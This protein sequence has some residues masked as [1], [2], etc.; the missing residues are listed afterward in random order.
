MH[1]TR[2]EWSKRAACRGD[3]EADSLFF[4][5]QKG[6]PRKNP[7]HRRFCGNCL[8]KNFC[9]AFAIVH[10]ELGVWGNTTEAERSRLSKKYRQSLKE[11]AVAEGWYEGDWHDLLPKIH[12]PENQND[13]ESLL[14]LP[15]EDFL[16]QVP[17][18]V[19]EDLLVPVE[20]TVE[21]LVV[22]LRPSGPSL[23]FD[24]PTGFQF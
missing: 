5:E 10:E 21:Q 22:V 3:D 24:D 4:S 1:P 18:F 9:L 2:S 6:R 13:L 8:V 12:R 15:L 23:T 11:Q 17:E 14:E 20:Q 16:L 7:P 19:I